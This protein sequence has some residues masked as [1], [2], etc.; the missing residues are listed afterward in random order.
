MN[1]KPLTYSD[2]KKIL[3]S[4]SD[5][6]GCPRCRGVV[7]EAEKVIAGENVWFHKACF[8]CQLCHTKLDSVRAAVGLNGDAFC[9]SCYRSQLEAERA[10][11]NVVAKPKNVIPCEP[12]DPSACPR[13]NGKVFEA[14]KMVSR[15][16]MFHKECF[17]CCAC[18]HKLDYSNCMEGPN[19]EVYCK[20]CYVKEYFTGGRNKFGDSGANLPVSCS[21]KEGC[22]KCRKQVFEVDKVMGK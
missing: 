14:E 16:R 18:A 3:A 1:T 7:Y 15:E 20:T 8:D 4:S 11:T 22:L 5:E 17:N 13:C 9:T 19:S 21:E 10:R 2:T 12:G 6:H